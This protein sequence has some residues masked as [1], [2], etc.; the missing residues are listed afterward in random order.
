MLALGS[1]HFRRSKRLH[2][3]L[4]F[5]HLPVSVS[6]LPTPPPPIP[7]QPACCVPPCRECDI[8]S[9]PEMQ[10]LLKSLTHRPWFKS[11]HALVLSQ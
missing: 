4:R 11:Q 1:V 7:M 8:H 9:C 6:L 3:S 5:L 2:Q 10:C